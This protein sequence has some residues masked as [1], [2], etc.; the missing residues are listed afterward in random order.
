MGKIS[1]EQVLVGEILTEY[2]RCSFKAL[3]L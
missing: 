2:C 3:K 1:V